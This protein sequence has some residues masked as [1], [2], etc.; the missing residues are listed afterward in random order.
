MIEDVKTTKDYI[1][2]VG[3]ISTA[4]LLSKIEELSK[5][6]TIEKDN[7]KW[8][9]KKRI[10]WYDECR[11]SPK[12]YDRSIKIL[13]DLGFVDTKVYKFNG[14]PIVHIHFIGVPKS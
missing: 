9:T 6:Q 11:L 4:I 7:K 5:K 8:I 1:D 3:D 10:D 14:N 2:I 12:Q 13:L